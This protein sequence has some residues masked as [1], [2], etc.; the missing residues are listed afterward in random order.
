MVLFKGPRI[1]YGFWY[2][3]GMHRKWGTLWRGVLI[4]LYIY[5]LVSNETPYILLDIWFSAEMYVHLVKQ[6]YSDFQ[7]L[8][9][10]T[11]FLQFWY[12]HCLPNIA[13]SSNCF[14]IESWGLVCL[15][16]AHKYFRN[17][18]Q[19]FKMF[20]QGVPNTNVKTVKRD[21]VF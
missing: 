17:L 16:S 7:L 5:E 9:R 15:Q 8:R 4:S 11:I 20:T 19:R 13:I 2:L 3:D 10:Y 21:S 18:T 14:N 6:P 12:L 1:I